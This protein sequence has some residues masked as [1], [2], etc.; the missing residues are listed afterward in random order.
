MEEFLLDRLS[1]VLVELLMLRRYNERLQDGKGRESQK[2]S[3]QWCG[4]GFGGPGVYF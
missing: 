4:E 3:D 2:S 1:F